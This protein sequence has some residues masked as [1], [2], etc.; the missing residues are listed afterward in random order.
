[1]ILN[2]LYNNIYSNRPTE[3]KTR[4]LAY[5]YPSLG[6]YAVYPPNTATGYGY[7]QGFF[8]NPYDGDPTKRYGYVFSYW[9]DETNINNPFINPSE[10]NRSI[11]SGSGA[12]I[13]GGNSGFFLPAATGAL[14]NPLQS[15]SNGITHWIVLPHPAVRGVATVPSLTKFTNMKIIEMLRMPVPL[16]ER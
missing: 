14:L 12:V 15:Q 8:P 2:S 9:G 3:Y 4:I 7:T 11:P 10:G 13:S 1:M 5:E 6:A 16:S